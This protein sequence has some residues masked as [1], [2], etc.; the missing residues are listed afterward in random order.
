[1]NQKTLTG[2]RNDHA[3]QIRN[4]IQVQFHFCIDIAMKRNDSIQKNDEVN[5]NGSDFQLQ[6]NVD[7]QQ[8]H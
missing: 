5:S 2:K 7:I 6:R 3:M 8:L 4:R 1:M